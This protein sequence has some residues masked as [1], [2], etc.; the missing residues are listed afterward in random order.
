MSRGASRWSAVASQ[1]RRHR[2][3]TVH[4]ASSAL[5][6]LNPQLTPLDAG[7]PRGQEHKTV[8]AFPAAP[9]ANLG[10]RQQEKRAGSSNIGQGNVQISL[11]ATSQS[12]LV[13][14]DLPE[15]SRSL[16]LVSH[17]RDIGPPSLGVPFSESPRRQ[18]KV[19]PRTSSSSLCNSLPARAER[20]RK[21]PAPHI[22]CVAFPFQAKVPPRLNV[23]VSCYEHEA[24]VLKN[25]SQAPNINPDSSSSPP[26]C[27][28]PPTGINLI[29]GATG[30]VRD[31]TYPLHP[32]ACCSMYRY[33]A[34]LGRRVSQGRGTEQGA[35]MEE[36]WSATALSSSIQ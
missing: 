24:A 6:Q 35:L 28:T 11:G 4:A 8:T 33:R 34:A 2:H 23:S 17:D 3:C 16:P 7:S 10:A 25:T 26:T 31:P 13:I 12:G 27:C 18:C 14:N 9:A 22:L 19:A 15:D 30:S 36:S 5:L 32:H 21:T 1:P 20:K 29:C